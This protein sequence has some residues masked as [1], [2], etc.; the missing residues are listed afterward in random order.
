VLEKTQ[1]FLIQYSLILLIPFLLFS[2]CKDGTKFAEKD[3]F[4]KVYEEAIKVNKD[5]L[6]YTSMLDSLI[7]L[8]NID[9]I[10]EQRA[11]AFSLKGE[12]LLSKQKYPQALI[13]FEKSIK[14]C[15]SHNLI[16]QMGKDLENCGKALYRMKDRYKAIDAFNKSAE[17][18]EGSGD[19][20]GL[21]SA[22]NNV[23]FMY[24]ESSIY[25]SA[26]IYFNKALEIRSKLT[27]NYQLASTLNNLGTVYYNWAV[28]DKAL[29]YY[30]KSLNIQRDINND[31]GIAIALSN[32]GLIYS[33]T[34]QQEEAIQYY[35][36]S[37]PYA[38][39]CK[40]TQIVGYIYQGMGQAFENLNIDSCLS[41]LTLALETYQKTE[42]S[43]GIILSLKGMGSFYLKLKNFEVAEKHFRDMLDMSVKDKIP[44]REAEALKGIG[45]VYLATNQFE[46]SKTFLLK[47]DSLAKNLNNKVLLKDL[48]KTISKVEEKLGNKEGSFKAIKEYLDYTE[49][50]QNDE[51]NRKLTG[52]KNKFQFQKYERDLQTQIYENELQR[53]VL[54]GGGFVLFFIAVIAFVLYRLNKKLEKANQ[55]L[56]EK[57]EL[58]DG[59]S[60][61]LS[62]KN[63]ELIE[64]NEAKDKLFSIIAHDLKSPF[65]VFLGL[66]SV[67]KDEFYELTNQEKI[68]LVSGLEET[69]QKTYDLLEN[70]LNLSA[71]RIG[72]LSFTPDIINVYPLAEKI[73]LLFSQPASIKKVKLINSIKQDLYITA[74]MNMI[75]IVIRN[76]VNNALK[77]SLEGGL[78]ELASSES[79]DLVSLSVHDNGI[80]MDDSTKHNIFNIGSIRSQRGTKGEKGTGLGL[81]LCKEFVEK[82]SGVIEV[83]S[84][85]G[86]GT[87]FII[88]LPKN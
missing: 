36:E 42:S 5:S 46:K 28:Y 11:Q 41:Y 1:V 81:G 58:I 87:N 33:E 48:R 32:I 50:I 17:I 77:Y 39:S 3:A 16:L 30:M 65:Q 19:S 69:A 27:N 13:L 4:K 38:F 26:I 22:L 23:G 7:N 52:L 40:D 8:S 43:G 18:C 85:L 71:S 66:T 55:L 70:L 2:G 86:I 57:N 14:I 78:I 67:L 59:Q 54:F 76:L 24:W 72:K 31:Y 60:K 10:P 73:L 35:R 61:E 88:K 53:I 12:Y 44:L 56:H 25:D 49:E 63:S 68:E 84:E 62:Q 64:S 29:E 75:E 15:E 45:E 82:H 6:I 37:L 9:K 74:D 80:G 21:G 83:Q 34:T 79:D 47:S 20:V 51:M